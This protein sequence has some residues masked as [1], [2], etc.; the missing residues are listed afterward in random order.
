MWSPL[1]TAASGSNASARRSR[2]LRIAVGRKPLRSPMPAYV[3]PGPP[4]Q[5]KKSRRSRC[6]RA[7]GAG[8]VDSGHGSHSARP[9]ASAS[10]SV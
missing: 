3:P 2:R 7:S 1:A 9:P 8:N 10:D 4:A 5:V 6:G